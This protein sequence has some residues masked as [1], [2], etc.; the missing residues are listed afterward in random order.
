MEE[1]NY[2]FAKSIKKTSK[3]P[4][5]IIVDDDKLIRLVLSRLLSKCGYSVETT[6]NISGMWRLISG[7]NT[8][9]LIT[10]V[11]LP[12]GDALN[13]IPRIKKNFSNLPII[14]MSAQSTLIT[15]V[16]ANKIG[17]FDY[18]SKPFDM[19]IVLEL[20]KNAIQLKYDDT[21]SPEGNS[22]QIYTKSEDSFVGRSSAMQ[23]LYRSISKLVNSNLSV[24][25]TGE[26]GT[27]KKLIA[28]V[29]HSLDKSRTGLFK[30]LNMGS[31]S[32]EQIEKE[33]LGLYEKNN[34][35]NKA[36]N[37]GTLLLNSIDDMSLNAQAIF[38][39]LLQSSTLE[40]FDLSNS[41]I[42]IIASSNKSI[43]KLISSGLFREDLYYRL[44]VIPLNVPSLRDRK[45]DIP[46][47]VNH[48]VEKNSK[49]GLAIKKYNDKALNELMKYN[50]P[51]NVRE[52]ENVIK[53]LSI[54]YPENTISTL[55]IKNEIM[56]SSSIEDENDGFSLSVEKQLK[57]YFENL[58]GEL[59]ASGFF[60]RIIKEVERP[61]IKLTLDSTEGNQIKA[62][63]ILGINRNTLRKKIK[64]LEIKIIKRAKIDKYF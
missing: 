44:N 56:K 31:M 16:K 1:K 37:H 28:K 27:G 58:K 38:M 59:P 19:N 2:S 46:Y 9:L 51:G 17:A 36:F 12:D 53:R 45:E 22:N 60:N 10:D 55:S 41:N 40:Q 5:I 34:E 21:K 54:L 18:I 49:E 63:D 57:L 7:G 3:K 8:D 52:L 62:A 15:A 30:I 61:L 50:W 13:V 48:F 11:K 32:K 26:I 6:G 33:I 4:L 14:V 24:M 39:R 23:Q 35:E 29:I 47:L 64:D 42:R 43:P 20:V 25:I